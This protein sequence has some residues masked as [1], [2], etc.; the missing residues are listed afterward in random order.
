MNNLRKKFRQ[1]ILRGIV[2]TVTILTL[3]IVGLHHFYKNQDILE[4]VKLEILPWILKPSIYVIP[5]YED[6]KDMT[7]IPE[8]L[9]LIGKI[10]SN[11]FDEDILFKIYYSSTV[12][13]IPWEKKPNMNEANNEVPEKIKKIPYD[14]F[15]IKDINFYYSYPLKGENY[16]NY[17]F[18]PKLPNNRTIYNIE[19]DPYI[20]INYDNKKKVIL[21][22]LNTLH[23]LP[24]F[25]YEDKSNEKTSLKE[26]CDLENFGKYLSPIFSLYKVKFED[27]IYAK[28]KN[29]NV[30]IHCWTGYGFVVFY[31]DGLEKL[32]ANIDCLE[33]VINLQRQM[34]HQ[35]MVIEKRKE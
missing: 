14:I 34:I 30:V 22:L 7:I 28:N 16:W 24:T 33:I 23:R 12:S 5:I 13:I 35:F 31:F 20:L 1:Y 19:I 26:L 27:I 18:F 29:E 21:S 11:P 17:Y 8:S 4:K 9:Y 32:G 3:L 10:I 15:G 2:I 6:I 25:L